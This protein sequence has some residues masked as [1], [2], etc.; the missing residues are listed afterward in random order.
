MRLVIL[1][2]TKEAYCGLVIFTVHFNNFSK[3]LVTI[4]VAVTGF[5]YFFPDFNNLMILTEFYFP[6]RNTTAFTK[7]L[8]AFETK[9]F[10]YYF[11]FLWTDRTQGVADGC[12][13]KFSY[14]YHFANEKVTR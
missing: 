2:K 9:H 14:I 8:F 6:V 12:T 7:I 13:R 4:A 11:L 5:L 1:S 3:M 10:G